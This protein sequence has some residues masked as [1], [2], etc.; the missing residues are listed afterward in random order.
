MPLR[1]ELP[2]I[3]ENCQRLRF[4]EARDN[5][6]AELSAKRLMNLLEQAAAD[7]ETRPD[8]GS[9]LLIRRVR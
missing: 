9:A 3:G 6:G 7:D 1:Q 2:E 8:F 5:D 4:G